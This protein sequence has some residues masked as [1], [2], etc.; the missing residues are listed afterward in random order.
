[1]V[2]VGVDAVYKAERLARHALWAAPVA[3]ALVRCSVRGIEYLSP[4]VVAIAFPSPFPLLSSVI[5]SFA[6]FLPAPFSL[7]VVACLFSPFKSKYSSRVAFLPNS[8]DMRAT[9][10]LRISVTLNLSQSQSSSAS[11]SLSLIE[12]EFEPEFEFEPTYCG[13]ATEPQASAPTPSPYPAR[14]KRPSNKSKAS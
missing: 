10:T 5:F 11:R 4:N 8:K 6:F 3:A 13:R 7:F 1:M 2:T 12:S 9:Y 14:A